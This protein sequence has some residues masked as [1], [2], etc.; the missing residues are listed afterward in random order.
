LGNLGYKEGLLITTLITNF[1][2]SPYLIS[3][4]HEKLGKMDTKRCIYRRGKNSM[5]WDA[6]GLTKDVL[7]VSI[8]DVNHA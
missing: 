4:Y 1:I 2:G 8:G 7:I 5:T 3:M 6:Y